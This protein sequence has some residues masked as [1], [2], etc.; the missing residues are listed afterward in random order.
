MNTEEPRTGGKW[1]GNTR[2]QGCRGMELL[3]I[4]GGTSVSNIWKYAHHWTESTRQAR[5]RSIGFEGLKETCSF[6][7]GILIAKSNNQ[8]AQDKMKTWS[9]LVQ[10]NYKMVTAEHCTKCKGLC[11]VTQVMCPA[12]WNLDGLA[13]WKQ[14]GCGNNPAQTGL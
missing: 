5:K 10:Q 13:W 12:L 14:G 8:G 11:H 2:S 4:S 7:N 1:E 3:G 9:L 6:K